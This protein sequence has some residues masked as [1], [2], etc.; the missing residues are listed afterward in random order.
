[1]IDIDLQGGPFLIGIMFFYCDKWQR[2]PSNWSHPTLT[3][4]IRRTYSLVSID[5]WPWTVWF[6]LVQVIIIKISV[7]EAPQPSTTADRQTSRWLLVKSTSNRCETANIIYVTF[8]VVADGVLW[9]RPLLQTIIQ[10]MTL[11]G[12][13][14]CATCPTL[15]THSL[16]VSAHWFH[17]VT[18]PHWPHPVKSSIIIIPHLP[19]LGVPFYSS[20]VYVADRTC[21]PTRPACRRTQTPAPRPS[22]RQMA[23][24]W[25]RWLRTRSSWP[26][27]IPGNCFGL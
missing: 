19:P 9:G 5:G 2:S 6:L 1:M 23:C 13:T 11:T 17:S 21:G 25:R 16:W 20:A 27:S 22:P 14:T 4:Q 3:H 24:I 7:F 18:W 12:T 15:I 26:Q 10:I 8:I